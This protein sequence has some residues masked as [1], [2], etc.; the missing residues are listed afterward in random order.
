MCAGVDGALTTSAVVGEGSGEA[1]MVM[2]RPVARRRRIAG[3]EG[4]AGLIRVRRHGARGRVSGLALWA[5]LSLDMGLGGRGVGRLGDLTTPEKG[6]RG[7][8]RASL[9]RLQALGLDP[10]GEGDNDNRG[11]PQH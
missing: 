9:R 3:M 4:V 5:V 1:M 11:L 6:A 7:P 10:Q 2:A 8:S